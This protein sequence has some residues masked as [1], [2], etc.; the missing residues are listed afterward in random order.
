MGG[1]GGMMGCD[2]IIGWLQLEQQRWKKLQLPDYY[3]ISCLTAGF[4]RI[5]QSGAIRLRLACD[6]RSGVRTV[7]GL[8]LDGWRIECNFFHS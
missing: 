8:M 4:Y 7:A 3:Y 5:E 2:L 1:M 6:E